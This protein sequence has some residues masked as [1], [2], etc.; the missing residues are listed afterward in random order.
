M[1]GFKKEVFLLNISSVSE[2]KTFFM[3][4]TNIQEKNV[5]FLKKIA[6]VTTPMSSIAQTNNRNIVKICIHEI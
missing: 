2:I 3:C 5:F 6:L 4:T 1:R